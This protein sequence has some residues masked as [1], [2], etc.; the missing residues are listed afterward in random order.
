MFRCSGISVIN[1]A[2]TVIYSF[3]LAYLRGLE[4][5]FELITLSK[6]NTTDGNKTS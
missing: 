1:P 2:D 5:H 6:R 3:K 4:A